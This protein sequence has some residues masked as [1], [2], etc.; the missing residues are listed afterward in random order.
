[1]SFITCS[2]LSLGR[3][4]RLS[5]AMWKSKIHRVLLAIVLANLAM[6]LLAV[7]SWCRLM[8]PPSMADVRDWRKKRLWSFADTF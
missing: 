3:T 2:R 1:M 8:F 5:E 7:Q 4:P 6:F